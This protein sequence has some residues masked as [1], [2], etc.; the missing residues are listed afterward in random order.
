[1]NRS[2][3][4]TRRLDTTDRE[5]IAALTEDGRMTVRDLAAQIG[6]SSPSATDR[7]LKLKDAG[8]ITGYTVQ[9]DP[10]GFGLN[11]AA[12]VRI[13]AMPGEVKRVAQM[14]SD[15]PEVVEADRVTGADCFLAKVL[16]CDVQELEAV[17][18]R[19]VPFAATHTAI[20][21]S[22]TV[23]RRLPKLQGF[24]CGLRPDLTIQPHGSVHMVINSHIGLAIP[25]PKISASGSPSP[26]RRCRTQ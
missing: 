5:I 6:Q 2:R 7:I 16:V 23:V 9:V 18:N 22:S 19:F 4:V 21:Q 3:Y 17:V 10:K 20:I 1:M 15:T 8:A 12:Y 13:R 24:R 25:P 26:L 14:L 11:I